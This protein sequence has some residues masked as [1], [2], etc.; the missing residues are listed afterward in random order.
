MRINYAKQIDGSSL[1]ELYGQIFQSSY[2]ERENKRIIEYGF[3][4]N[5]GNK[6]ISLTTNYIYIRKNKNIIGC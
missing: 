4:G 2:Y 5:L 3:V 1:I 6:E